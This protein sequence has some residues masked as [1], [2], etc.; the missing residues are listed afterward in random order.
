MNR[1]FLFGLVAVSSLALAATAAQ[2]DNL[3]GL[4]GNTAVCTA[5][6]GSA[7]KVYVEAGGVFTLTLPNGQSI[8]GTVK[9]DGSQIC[10]TETDPAP[11]SGAV[12]V[13]LPATP[14]KVGDTWT[15]AARD[16]TQSCS[17]KAGRQ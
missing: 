16:L 5:P 1:S 15:V 7:T 6:D 4:T 14:R 11:A 8:K 3:A 9:D 13:C 2:A 17:L 10:Y 12:P